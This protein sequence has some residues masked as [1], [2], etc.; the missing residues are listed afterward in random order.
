MYEEY[1]GVPG[2]GRGRLLAWGRRA[3]VDGAESEHSA[4]DALARA[5]SLAGQAVRGLF[6]QA[7]HADQ[8]DCRDRQGHDDGDGRS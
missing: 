4:R 6:A 5:R 7:G 8:D 1:F 2:C 3:D